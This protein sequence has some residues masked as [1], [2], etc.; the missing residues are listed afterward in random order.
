MTGLAARVAAQAKINLHL[1]VFDRDASGYHSIETVFQRIE[2]SDWLT[3][4]ITGG[5]R[6]LDVMSALA[7]EGPDLGPPETN[8]A[9]RAAEAYAEA[10]DWPPGF[11]IQLTKWIPV[12]AGL[13]GGSADAAGVL[14]LLNFLA[15]RP[16]PA[17]RLHSIAAELGSD[18]PFLLSDEV[19]AI[20]TGRGEQILPLPQLQRRHVLLAVPHFAVSTKE[21]YSWLDDDRVAGLIPNPGAQKLEDPS[22]FSNWNALAA[23]ARNDFLEPV[24]RH[25]PALAGILGALRETGPVFASMTGSGSALFGIYEIEPTIPRDA[26]FRGVSI[27]PTRTA[28]SV[29]QPTRLG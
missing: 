5:Q 4:R 18:V 29:V 16:M 8:L 17:Q 26:A 1:R 6:T 15:L 14:R 27:T 24:T 28:T 9:Y 13:G 25:Y 2:T 7:T 22:E 12:G 11:D 10:A 23:F 21:A 20:G 3:L 19:M